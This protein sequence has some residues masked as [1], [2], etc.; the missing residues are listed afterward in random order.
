MDSSVVSTRPERTSLEITADR[1]AAN[2]FFTRFDTNWNVK[3]RRDLSRLIERESYDWNLR[4]CTWEGNQR[5][6]DYNVTDAERTRRR[7]VRESVYPHAHRS[8]DNLRAYVWT[9]TLANMPPTAVHQ[10]TEKERKVTTR[11]AAEYWHLSVTRK[12][13]RRRILNDDRLP[14]AQWLLL[15]PSYGPLH[16]AP[17]EHFTPSYARYKKGEIRPANMTPERALHI[18]LAA[19]GAAKR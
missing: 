19:L 10:R 9:D 16:E 11:W 15:R 5:A 14:F 12:N 3:E 17:E 13:R 2:A 18:A 8:D 1:K 7:T 4:C 6:A